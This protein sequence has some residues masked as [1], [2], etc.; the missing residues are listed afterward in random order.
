MVLAQTNESK[1]NTPTTQNAN[2]QDSLD[3]QQLMETF[4]TAV[5]SHDGSALSSLFV[6]D[7]SAWFNVLSDSAYAGAKAKSETAMKIRKSDYR[8]F[9]KFVSTTKDNLDP[10]HSNIQIRSD[11]T[12]ASVYF[13]FVFLINGKEENSGSETWQLVK[14]S[15]G[16]Q[17]A[18][19][20][21]SSNPHM[22]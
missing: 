10:R 13:D 21:Y 19:I 16:W 15:T 14:G 17:I 4:H 12:I 5:I 3:I 7:G 1:I 20:S 9:A 6:Q 2:D 22:K 18:A 8:D 11:G